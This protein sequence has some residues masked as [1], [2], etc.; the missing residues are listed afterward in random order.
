MQVPRPPFVLLV[1]L[2][3]SLPGGQVSSQTVVG[4]LLDGEAFQPIPWGII[5]LLDS[6]SHPISLTH[7]DE[8]G[9]FLLIA[10]GAGRYLIQA[11][12]YSFHTVQDG[13]VDLGPADTIRVE[14]FILPDPERLDPLV[15]EAERLDRRLR[16]VGFYRRKARGLGE[17]IA[18]EDIDD[19]RPHDMSS[20]LVWGSTG[21]LLR[22]NSMGNLAPAFLAGRGGTG[23]YGGGWCE[24]MY[25][26]DGL[27]VILERGEDIDSLIHPN[28]VGAV[29]VYPSPGA[30]PAQYRDARA[31][32]GTILIWTR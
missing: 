5:Q 13:P 26:V 12:A 18:R 27:P 24:P 28:R 9:D 23:V 21:I 3:M 2:G 22:P 7:S 15:V 29:E 8:N 30:T 10:P 4:R 16:M 19:I 6:V 11:E 32:C 31:G 20:L 1:C 14:F 25:F 17:F